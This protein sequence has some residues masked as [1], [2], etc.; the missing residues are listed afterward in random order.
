MAYRVQPSIIGADVSSQ[1]I[2]L[3]C[4]G[5]PHVATTIDNT[6]TAID[7]W[8]DRQPDPTCLAVESTGSYHVELV[9]RAHARGMV[10]YLINPYQLAH[11]RKGVGVR[12]KTDIADAHL[13]ARYLAHECDQ[14]RA[15]QPP[16][17]GQRR[18]WQLLRRR[19]KLVKARDML[20][21][22]FNG[23]SGFE[24]EYQ[25]LCQQLRRLEQ[26]LETR[27]YRLLAR[28]GWETAYQC[29]RSIPGI[30]PLSAAALTAAYHRGEFRRADAF[31]AF[32][33]LDV[34]I[35]QSGKY[36]G[37][38]KLTKQGDPETRRILHNAAVTAARYHFKPYYERLLGKGMA[39]VQAHVAL[40][41]KLVRIAFSLIKND[42]EFDPKLAVAG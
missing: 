8:L 13:L 38:S 29:C 3:A 37:R 28:Q 34:R 42:R 10:V 35:R 22:S 39:P 21:Q 1:S 27:L 6:A 19:A 16:P 25:A 2:D 7:A 24:Q 32:L 36:Q 20:K 4:Y 17:K 26:A 15:W 23:L 31:V 14:L 33:G 30:G 5:A 40:T 11:Y 41:R 9:E 12:S 18:A